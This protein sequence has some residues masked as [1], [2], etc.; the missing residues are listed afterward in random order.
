[1]AMAVMLRLPH[2]PDGDPNPMA[3]AVE[4]AGTHVV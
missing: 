3:Q 4:R 1:M 2:D